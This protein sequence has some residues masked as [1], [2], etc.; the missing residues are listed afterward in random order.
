MTTT[1]VRE[2]LA[3]L[4]GKALNRA[5]SLGQTY[6]QQADSASYRENARAHATRGIY[7]ALREETLAALASHPSPAP[8]PDE[9]DA[10]AELNCAEEVLDSLAVNLDLEQTH[11]DCVGDYIT[12]VVEATRRAQAEPKVQAQ[13]GE[14]S[15]EDIAYPADVF[16]ALMSGNSPYAF[17]LFQWV[18]YQTDAKHWRLKMQHDVRTF[19]GREAFNIWPNASSC[20]PFRDDEVEF[21]R[22]SKS[23]FGDAWQ[24]PRPDRPEFA[25]P[26][27]TPEKADFAAQAEDLA[28]LGWQSLFCP[29]CGCDGARGYPH[30]NKVMK[31]PETEPYRWN[32]PGVQAIHMILCLHGGDDPTDLSCRILDILK[33]R[34]FKWSKQPEIEVWFGSMPE[35]NG[36]ENWTVTLRRKDRPKNADK[37]DLHRLMSGITVYRSEYKDRARYEADRLRHLL[38]EIDIAPNIL[39]YDADLHSGYVPE[40]NPSDIETPQGYRL[41]KD[42]T[43]AERS[44]SEDT[45]LENGNYSNTCCNCFRSFIGH[46]RRVICKSCDSLSKAV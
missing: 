11:F 1:N 31:K 10:E 46:K 12:A 21:I 7:E 17:Y 28:K 15:K 23:Q 41:L 34:G 16:R 37:I 4:V 18:P 32:E 8:Q 36:R 26:Q 45:S 39:D 43:H 30:P 9:R 44:W 20:G 25:A 35:S 19:D 40:I 3:E 27:P 42:T 6:W 13:A 2:A 22:I 5:W 24:D 29:A 38:G 33:E 14:L